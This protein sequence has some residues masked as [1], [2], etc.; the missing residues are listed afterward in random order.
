MY[1]LSMSSMAKNYK[2]HS[3]FVY[4]TLH[5]EHR[6]HYMCQLLYQVWCHSTSKAF[7][8]LTGHIILTSIAC[9]SSR[10]KV[11]TQIHE[12]QCDNCWN[13]TSDSV[14]LVSSSEEE[15]GDDERDRQCV[16]DLGGTSISNDFLN[17]P[18]LSGE[19]EMESLWMPSLAL[20]EGISPPP[21]PSAIY[22]QQNIRSLVDILS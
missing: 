10:S 15:E 4:Y 7:H 13:C 21:P 17:T 3:Y 18:S 16:W 12:I 1:F 22:T 2:Y 5:I 8:C 19:L 14:V 20:F 11:T 6:G 9:P